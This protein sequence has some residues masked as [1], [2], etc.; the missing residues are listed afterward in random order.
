VDG[1]SRSEGVGASTIGIVSAALPTSHDV[2][3]RTPRVNPIA[4][5]VFCRPNLFG[6]SSSGR[7][8]PGQS[9]RIVERIALAP[10]VG[11]NFGSDPV[12]HWRAHLGR[13]QPGKWGGG[14]FN[15][16]IIRQV[17]WWFSCLSKLTTPITPATPPVPAGSRTATRC[18]FSLGQIRR[19]DQAWVGGCYRIT[20]VGAGAI[21]EGRWTVERR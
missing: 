16:P 12:K 21:R 5:G 15:L 2:G 17:A 11:I 18:V 14:P 7:S 13:I 4:R 3:A 10:E 20:P 1:G 9:V 6:H 8:A 19:P